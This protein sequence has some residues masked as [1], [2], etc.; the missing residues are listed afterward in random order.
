MRTTILASGLIGLLFPALALAFPFG[1]RATQVSPCYNNAIIAYVGAP[2]GGV[3]IWT[4]S[5]RTYQFGAPT[6][7]GQWLLGLASAPYYCIISVVPIDVRAGIAIQMLGT[8]QQ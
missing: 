5:T 4:P 2:R 8:S 3:Y 6:H 1:G 7:A